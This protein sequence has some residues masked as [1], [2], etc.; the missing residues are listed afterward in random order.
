ME[1]FEFSPYQFCSPDI[2][3]RPRPSLK[4]PLVPRNL[5]RSSPSSVTG[6]KMACSLKGAG[7]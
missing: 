1:K 2:P 5:M 4:V 3:G 6:E 7:V